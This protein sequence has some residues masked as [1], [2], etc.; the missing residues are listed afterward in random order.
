MSAVI[1]R[2]AN[3]WF[4]L[5]M[6]LLSCVS[7]GQKTTSDE[8]W[9][10][11]LVK[12]DTQCGLKGCLLMT[13]VLRGYSGDPAPPDSKDVREYIGIYVAVNRTT[14]K[15]VYFAFHVDPNS[16]KDQGLFIA[17]TKTIKGDGKFKT[18]LDGDGASRLPFSS[19]DHDSCVARIPEGIVEQGKEG[20]RLD[21]LEKFLDSDSVLI[22]YMKNGKAYRTMILLSSFKKEYTKLLSSELGSA[23]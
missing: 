4:S 9:S 20:H 7:A 18:G 15:P 17:F 23:P 11:D 19:C 1:W 5:I 13:D 16:Q 6:I 8:D 21:L 14:R 22:L 12:W 2:R 3:C 10:D